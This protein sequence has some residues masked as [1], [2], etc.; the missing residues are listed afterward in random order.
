VDG[1]DVAAGGPG[2]GF[3]AAGAVVVVEYPPARDRVADLDDAAAEGAALDVSAL[4]LH[5]GEL[6]GLATVV[7]FAH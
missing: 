6:S 3:A 5:A 4:S 1:D 2:A 7:V